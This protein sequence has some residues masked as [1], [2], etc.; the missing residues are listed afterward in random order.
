MT[1]PELSAH[2]DDAARALAA[3]K[4]HR[5]E[6]LDAPDTIVEI[7]QNHR[8][9]QDTTRQFRE[10]FH[11]QSSEIAGV[12]LACNQIPDIERRVHE[13]EDQNVAVLAR[14]VRWLEQRVDSMARALWTAAGALV[15][16]AVTFA[17][18]VASG[19]I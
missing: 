10:R 3:Y 9:Q 18:A 4:K 14:D 19:Q 11:A 16:A 13:L 6:G 2:L 5:A 8:E 17:L 1:C 7:V 12:T 15:I